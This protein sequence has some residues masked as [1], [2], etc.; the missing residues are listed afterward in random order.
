MHITEENLAQR[1]KFLYS[2]TSKI[3]GSILAAG[4]EAALSLSTKYFG[5]DQLH[6]C[7]L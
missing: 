4:E 6:A 2:Y 1:V 3:D 5:H 7:I